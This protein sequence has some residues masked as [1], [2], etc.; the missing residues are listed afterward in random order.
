MGGLVLADF[1]PLTEAHWTHVYVGHPALLRCTS[2]VNR[3][4]YVGIAGVTLDEEP[5]FEIH[6]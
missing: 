2:D 6:R 3:V 5:R 1:L 4:C